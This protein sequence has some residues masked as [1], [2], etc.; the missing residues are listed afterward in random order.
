[1]YTTVGTYY[2]FQMNVYCPGLDR[3]NP[4]RTTDSHLKRIISTK[5]C[6]Y[7]FVP[8]DNGPRYARNMQRLTKYTK[9]KLCVKLVFLYTIVKPYLEDLL[10][11]NCRKLYFA[12]FT[13]FIHI[14]G[15]R[16]MLG[17]LRKPILQPTN[18]QHYILCLCPSVLLFQ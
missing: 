5:C 11:A 2:S 12:L 4:T 14:S 17:L 7:T 1:M 3:N 13:S 15:R 16:K 6:I 10:I 9:N 18:I 8:P